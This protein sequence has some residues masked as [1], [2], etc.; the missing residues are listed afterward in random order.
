MIKNFKIRNYKNFKDL[1][2]D[3]LGQFNLLVGNNNTGKS[4]ILE[5]ILLYTN[6]FDLNSWRLVLQNRNEDITCFHAEGQTEDDMISAIAPLCIDRNL[7]MFKDSTDNSIV[8][9]TDNDYLQ[10]SLTHVVAKLTQ[11]GQH[12]IT[13]MVPYSEENKITSNMEEIRPAIISKTSRLDKTTFKSISRIA[14]RTIKSL[15][16]LDRGC[17]AKGAFVSPMPKNPIVFLA[18]KAIDAN[19][20]E[21]SWSKISM[22]PMELE[23]SN[24]LQLVYPNVNKVN[25]LKMPD[26][27]NVPFVALNNGVRM[28][29]SELGDG[30]THI[31]NILIALVSAQNGILLLDEVESGLHYTTLQT[32]WKSI[33]DI[34]T[35]LNVQVIATT[36]SV[37]CIKAFTDYN[38]ENNVHM[39]NIYSLGMNNNELTI[40]T[41][42]DPKQIDNLLAGGLEIR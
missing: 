28:P 15:V 30:M 42:D 10:V 3:N 40:K 23:F 2:I 35:R 31:A 36:H 4:N 1:S 39:G 24:I 38:I 16:W 14:L 37:D 25:L 33:F 9:G 13:K 19:L 12:T 20:F 11:L 21:K 22:T 32:I 6:N 17:L 8:L 18:C 34:A 41:Y 26:G 27:R 29:L 7:N 5:A